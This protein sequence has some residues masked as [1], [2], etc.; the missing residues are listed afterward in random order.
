LFTVTCEHV[1]IEFK[2][3][4]TA[5]CLNSSGSVS[6]ACLGA[7]SGVLTNPC[8]NDYK[9]ERKTDYPA[10]QNFFHL[11]STSTVY[12]ILHQLKS[13]K[14]A[15]IPGS[16]GVDTVLVAFTVQQVTLVDI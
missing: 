3:S 14:T 1:F 9:K 10:S 7:V 5:A 13:I 12:S 15:A 11:L 16:F 6:H 8:Q 4:V 2:P